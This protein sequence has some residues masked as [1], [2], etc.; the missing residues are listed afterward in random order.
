MIAQV[1]RLASCAVSASTGNPWIIAVK[2]V[3]RLT[4]TGSSSV[5]L[6]RGSWV[7]CSSSTSIPIRNCSTSKGA[8]SQSIPICSPMLLA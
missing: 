3:I 5:T 2:S 6:V 7:P 8:M 1:T 4:M